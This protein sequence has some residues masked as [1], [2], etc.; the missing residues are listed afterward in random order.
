[1]NICFYY[2]WWKIA[3][4][5]IAEYGKAGYG[6]VSTAVFICS[7]GAI[8]WTGDLSTEEEIFGKMPVYVIANTMKWRFVE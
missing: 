3:E 2:H 8:I 7:N 1:M 5:Y 6:F 4:E